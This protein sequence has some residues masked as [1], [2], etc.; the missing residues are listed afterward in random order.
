MDIPISKI[1]N[2]LDAFYGSSLINYNDGRDCSLYSKCSASCIWEDREITAP[3]GA[4]IG[5]EYDKYRI[6]FVGINTN[7]GSKDSTDFYSSKN[8]ISGDDNYIAGTIHRL[9][10]KI[11][12]KPTINPDDTKKYFAFTNAI[13]CSVNEKAGNPTQTMEINCIYLN[14]F[15]FNEI[16][17]LK[18]R[19]IIALGEIPF[20]AIRIN[21][22]NTIKSIDPL[23]NTWALTIQ[24][25]GNEI[26]IISLYNP[27]TGYKS[28][29]GIYNKMKKEN[30]VTGER[31]I[32][33][34]EIFNESCEI[35]VILESR[36]PADNRIDRANPFYDLMIDKLLCLIKP[37]FQLP[38]SDT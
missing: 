2:E 13:K 12:A 24:G 25:Q 33:T 35:G 29:R 21:Y 15:L 32:F 7:K 18:P 19:L 34:D 22:M 9:V 4:F 16:E 10:K 38:Q 8:W 6:L 17:I 14:K 5:D 20:K 3:T 31:R 26:A 23:F 28:L 1:R 27:G 11:V 37:I 30:R 36:Y